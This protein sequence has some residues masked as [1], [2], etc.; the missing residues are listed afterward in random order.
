MPTTAAS[1][2]VTVPA[3]VCLL[4]VW[5]VHARH[6]KRDLAEQLPLPLAAVAILGC[7][8]S[9]EW[10]VLAAG[11]VTAATVAVGVPLSR[12]PAPGAPAAAVPPNRM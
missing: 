7:T 11:L 10:A 3:A 6:F 2:A 1:A 9:R 4:T 12:R 5:L 8:F